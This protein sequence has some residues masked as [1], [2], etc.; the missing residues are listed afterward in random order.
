MVEKLFT[1]SP[2]CKE[3]FENMKEDVKVYVDY[4][5]ISWVNSL[6]KRFIVYFSNYSKFKSI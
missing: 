2:C 6:F 3:H 1:Y 5:I 4:H